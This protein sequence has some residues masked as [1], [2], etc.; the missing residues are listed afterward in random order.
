MNEWAPVETHCVNS[1][2]GDKEKRRRV[3]ALLIFNVINRAD[4]DLSGAWSWTWLQTYLAFFFLLAPRVTHWYSFL[5]YKKKE[6]P[7]QYLLECPNVSFILS[8]DSASGGKTRTKDKYR[9]VY[10]DQQRQE[11]EKEFQCNRY[12]TMRRKSE[13]SVALGLTERQVRGW[14]WAATS[15]TGAKRRNTAAWRT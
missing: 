13:L 2:Q 4:E 12:I 1:E 6:R 14:M 5:L 15:W 7:A 11:L 9:V 8:A 3:F 10:T